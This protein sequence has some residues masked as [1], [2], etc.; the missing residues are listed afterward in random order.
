MELTIKSKYALDA[1]KVCG[2]LRKHGVSFNTIVRVAEDIIFDK[3]LAIDEH[4]QVM[5][6]IF[7]VLYNDELYG[8][9]LWCED[10]L[11]NLTID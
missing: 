7:S 2:S 5:D 3:D 11:P 4:E 6:E 9:D 1:L 10:V 8:D